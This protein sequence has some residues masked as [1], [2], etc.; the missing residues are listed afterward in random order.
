MYRRSLARHRWSSWLS[1]YRTD[2]STNSG[3]F[4]SWKNSGVPFCWQA[5]CCTWDTAAAAVFTDF[6]TFMFG[7]SVSPI[8]RLHWAPLANHNA[9]GLFRFCVATMLALREFRSLLSGCIYI[10]I[11]LV[12]TPRPARAPLIHLLWFKQR[13][14]L[15]Q[16]KWKVVQ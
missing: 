16:A 1:V 13:I 12:I 11:T 7:A 14:S 9:A 4:S 15:F 10:S 6:K 8:V 3:G 2:A 5:F